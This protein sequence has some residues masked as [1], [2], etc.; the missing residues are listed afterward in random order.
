MLQ[1]ESD[2]FWSKTRNQPFFLVSLM[3]FGLCLSSN[4]KEPHWEYTHSSMTGEN[5]KSAQWLWNIAVPS[6]LT[7]MG[8]TIV[9]TFYNY[10]FSFSTASAG[11]LECTIWQ[12]Y[13]SLFIITGSNLLAC[14][15]SSI[16]IENF[17]FFF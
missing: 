7:M 16:W 13:F 2:T 15:G 11:A 4:S 9:F 12:V 6:T 17:V 5:S 10:L 8:M 3:K 1:K 14:T